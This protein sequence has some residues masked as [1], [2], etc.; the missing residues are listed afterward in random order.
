MSCPSVLVIHS[1]TI[2][3]QPFFDS[4]DFISS[5]PPDVSDDTPIDLVFINFIEDQLLETLNSVQSD[6]VYTD[7]DVLSYT[8]ISANEVLGLFA[9]QDWN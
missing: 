8:P 7:A 6:K 2:L 3:F 4:P 5:N 9:Q 1:P